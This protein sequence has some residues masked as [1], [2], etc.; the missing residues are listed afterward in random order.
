MKH[1]ITLTLFLLLSLKLSAQIDGI[2]YQAIIIGPDAL[3]LPGVDSEGNYLPSTNIAI[4]FSILDSQNRTIFL[5]IQNTTTDEFGRINLVI[6]EAEP[7]RFQGISWDGNPKDLKVEI[8]FNGGE[9][10]ED[11]SRET[12]TFVPYAFH[13]NITA[14]GTL[15]VDDDTSLNRE[16]TVEGPI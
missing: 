2:S 3:E 4:K 14:T 15:V 16:L 6:G 8:D 7:D 12:L 13:R 11:L 5:E 10:F 1:L 9:N